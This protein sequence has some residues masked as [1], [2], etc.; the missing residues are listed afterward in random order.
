MMGLYASVKRCGYYPGRMRGYVPTPEAI[1]DLMVEKL[2]SKREPRLGDR[3]LDPGCG[4]GA[5]IHGVLRWCDRNQSHVPEIVGVELDPRHVATAKASFDGVRGITILEEDFFTCDP[6]SFDFVIGNPPYVPITEI[7]EE[8]KGALK[9]SFRSAQGRFDLYMLFFERGMNQ[10]APAGRMVF[11]TPDKFLSVESC[12]TLRK[13][14][15]AFGIE[16]VALLPENTFAS[17]ATYPAVTVLDRSVSGSLFEVST[18]AG[19]TINVKVDEAGSSLMPQINGYV[20][21]DGSRKKLSQL[22]ERISAGVATGADKLFV[23]E[24]QDIPEALQPFSYPTVAGRQLVGQR[25]PITCDDRMLVPYDRRGVLLAEG[26][27][28]ALGEYLAEP[29][30]RQR[31]ER[32][33]CVARKPWYAFH[34][35]PPT[36]DIFRPKILCQD[37]VG[38]PRFWRDDKGEILPRHT[39]YY[40]VPRNP[41]LLRALCNYLNGP[42]AREWLKAHC[43]RAANGFLRL[44]STVLKELPVPDLADL[45]RRQG[46]LFGG[47][48]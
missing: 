44:Q 1:V 31:L 36:T 32:R 22:C 29:V 35:T 27:L 46:H 17:L 25:E 16:Q 9:A 24:A 30:R 41:E 2:F 3:L 8:E 43:Q 15:A 42:E 12:R 19:S 5:F 34:E 13:M 20:E 10:L 39:V 18:R 38:E 4:P 11:I 37:L 47:A 23:L 45:G 7:K 26:D 6:G 40:I 21:G 48:L 28:G 33:T 14:M